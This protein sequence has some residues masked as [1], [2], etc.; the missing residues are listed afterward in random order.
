MGQLYH[1]HILGMEEHIFGQ[2]SSYNT[3][4]VCTSL[5]AELLY[6]DREILTKALAVKL[7]SRKLSAGL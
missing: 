4:A 5:E 7:P 1:G 3:S 6:I 2:S